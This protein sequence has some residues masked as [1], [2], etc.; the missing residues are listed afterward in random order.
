MLIPVIVLPVVGVRLI[1]VIAL[2]TI[3]VRLIPVI[4]L[5]VVGVRLHFIED[6]DH[7]ADV[8]RCCTDQ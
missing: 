8:L 3:G 7:T 5:P 6:F 1:L 4:A 2:P